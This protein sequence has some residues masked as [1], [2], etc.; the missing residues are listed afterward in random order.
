MSFRFEEKILLHISDYLKIKDFIFNYCTHKLS[1]SKTIKSV[2]KINV[3]FYLTDNDIN[4]IH[5]WLM[6]FALK[7]RPNSP[8]WECTMFLNYDANPIP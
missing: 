4:N 1:Y 8:S 5:Q 2:H 6:L 7:F 3:S